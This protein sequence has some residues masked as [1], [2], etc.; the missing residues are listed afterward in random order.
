MNKYSQP[1]LPYE[2]GRDIGGEAELV[3]ELRSEV[4]TLQGDR[5]KLDRPDIDGLKLSRTYFTWMVSVIAFVCGT[6]FF[7]GN[8]GFV[9]GE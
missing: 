9:V 2:I 5:E 3:G 7:L 6:V 4:K 8:S 1:E